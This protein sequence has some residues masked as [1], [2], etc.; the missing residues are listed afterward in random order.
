MGVIRL[1]GC[2]LLVLPCVL[3]EF[4]RFCYYGSWASNRHAPNALRPGDINPSLCSHLSYSFLDLDDTATRIIP[5]PDPP[6]PE[7]L[8]TQFNN[9]KKRNRSLKTIASVGG[10]AMGTEAFI[11]LV[12]SQDLMNQFAGN[13]VTFLRTHNF[14]GLDLDWEYPGVEYR[15]GKP[16][17]KQRFVQLLKTVREA[18]ESDP[19]VQKGRERLLL[20]C[21]VG[22][23]E[24]LVTT[25]YNV[26][27]IAQYSDLINLMMYDFH[28]EWENT[29]NVHSALYSDFDLSVDRFVKLWVSEGAPKSKLL[30]GLPLYGRS[31]TLVDPNNN[32]VGAP[33]SEGHDMPYYQVCQ[34]IKEHQITPTTLSNERVPY[35]VHNNLWVGY[36]DRASIREKAQYLRAEGLAGAMVWAIDLD[37]FHGTCEQGQY[38][39]MNAL[40]LI[41]SPDNA[42][43]G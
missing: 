32:T 43:V 21:A 15:G 38:P 42:I 12:S 7:T 25:A 33:S 35:F 36:E 8:M 14:D 16:E 27:G 23:T 4:Y 18:F 39:L 30:M 6:H 1:I 28:G 13:A 37:D 20:T 17:E 2:I 34:M 41:I 22:V 5:T 19:E 9:L 24:D 40:N 11:K 10:W 29:V 3:T 26:T 31:F